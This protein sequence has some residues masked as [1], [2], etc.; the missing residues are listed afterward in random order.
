MINLV[1]FVKR[2]LGEPDYLRR[3]AVWEVH[4]YLPER[5]LTN[6]GRHGNISVSSKD[7]FVGRL[8]YLQGQFGL[9]PMEHVRKILTAQTSRAPGRL[10]VDVGAN[11]GTTSITFLRMGLF[12]RALAF[13]PEPRNL[14]LLK[15]NLAQNAL[16]D[17]V[18]IHEVALSQKTGEAMLALSEVNFGDHQL[19]MGSNSERRRT[20]TVPL[21]QLDDVLAESHIAPAEI[22]LLWMDAQGHEF[23]ILLGARSVLEQR[24]PIVTEFWP[25]GLRKANSSPERLLELIAEYY[26]T[27][28]DLSEPQPIPRSLRDAQQVLGRL[29]GPRDETDLL[30]L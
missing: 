30:F 20:I 3:R 18:T 15:R 6:R 23:D 14:A 21:V 9:E 12:Q 17:R 7:W 27:F 5:D 25:G 16:R 24:V 8:G 10:L 1:G 2:C 28:Y 13:E 26:S 22:G 4:R 11:I 19:M 29:T